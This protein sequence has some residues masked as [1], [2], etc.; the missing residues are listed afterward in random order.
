MFKKSFAAFLVVCFIISF[1]GT[2]ITTYVHG[3]S[4]VQLPVATVR[5]DTANSDNSYCGDFTGG[6]LSPLLKEHIRILAHMITALKNEDMAA[7]GNDVHRWK[8]NVAQMAEDK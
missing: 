4:L 7:V 1:A 5:T 2:A 8:D 3:L 6:K